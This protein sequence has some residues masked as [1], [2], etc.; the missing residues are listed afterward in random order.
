[1]FVQLLSATCMS[2]LMFGSLVSPMFV[3]HSSSVA[4]MESMFMLIILSA[5]V[6]ASP[7]APGHFQG[8]QKT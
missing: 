7:A 3:L 1:M 8:L 4:S 6:S 5:A 2:C